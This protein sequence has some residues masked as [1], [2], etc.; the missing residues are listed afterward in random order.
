MSVRKRTWFTKAELKKI[1]PR[2]ESYAKTAGRNDW[3]EY[4]A[5]AAASLEIKP[6]EA[7]VVAYIDQKGK[8]CF[9]TREKER[10]RRL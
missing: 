2:A 9:K 5:E 6:H 8:R 10:R 7:W 1:K 4:R 3:K